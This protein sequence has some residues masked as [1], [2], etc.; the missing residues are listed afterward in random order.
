MEYF[1][2]TFKDTNQRKFIT[3]RRYSKSAQEA[4]NIIRVEYPGS[5]IYEVAKVVNNW[6]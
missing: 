3:V 4:A 1:S 6:R 5:K 2:V